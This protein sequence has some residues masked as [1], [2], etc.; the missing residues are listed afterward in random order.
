[1]TDFSK[2]FEHVVGVEGGY[3]NDPRDPGGE[4]IYGI[5]RRDHPGAWA[6]G[7]PTLE[8]AKAIYRMG[9]WDPARC[10]YLPWPLAAF[11]FDAAVNQGVSTAVRLLQKA[12][13]TVQDGAIGKNTLA[14]IQR[15]DQRELCALFMAD[16][17]LRYTGTRNFDTYGRGWLKRLFV[18]A[19]A[20]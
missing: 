17:A 13:G 3:V 11:V 14:A 9:Y 20:A 19:M 1:M 5:T 15:A 8:Q 4:T 18:V 6:A 10:E 2:A 7:R 12:V 16:R